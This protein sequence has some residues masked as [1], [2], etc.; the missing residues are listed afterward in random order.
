M[1]KFQFENNL[2]LM[3][4]FV[5]QGHIF[6]QNK[7]ILNCNNILQYYYSIYCSFDQINASFKNTTKSYWPQTNFTLEME[8]QI[9]RIAF[10]RSLHTESEIWN[11]VF[12]RIR[13]P[14]LSKYLSR[15]RKRRKSNLVRIFLWRMKVLEAVCKRDWHNVRLY[16]FFNVQKHLD[17]NCVLSVQWPL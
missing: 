3:T 16:L 17:E 11:F 7:V 15:M 13:H 6:K 9:E 2:T 4:G 12:F 14:S 5:V 8:G 1:Y 10:L